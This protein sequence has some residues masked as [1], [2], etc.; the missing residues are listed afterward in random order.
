MELCEHPSTLS[1]VV[2]TFIEDDGR[3]GELVLVF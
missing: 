1:E 2:V 3:D